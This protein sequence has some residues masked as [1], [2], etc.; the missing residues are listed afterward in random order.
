MNEL[1]KMGEAQTSRPRG[2]RERNR[3]SRHRRILDCATALFRARGYDAV[4]IE[5][6]AEAAELSV[7][8]IYNYYKNKGDILVAIVAMEVNDVLATG[9]RILAAPPR[10]ARK[11]V[12]SLVVGYIDH[13]LTYLTKEMWRQAM[14]IA[15]AQATSPSG[16]VY[17][18]LDAALSQQTIDL[19]KRLI[20]MGALPRTVDAAPIGE[21]LFNAVNNAF[22]TFVKDDAQSL[23][24]LK[25]ILRRQIRALVATLQA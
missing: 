24:D 6:I 3:E 22:V 2:L 4:K 20:G 17:A 18:D 15:I 10:D 12:E 1:Q 19:L 8:T 9:A 23:P 21:L 25:T 5:E 16:K 7:G 11:A 14:A 13:S